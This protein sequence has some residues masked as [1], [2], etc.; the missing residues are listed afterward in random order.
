MSGVVETPSICHIS[1]QAHGRTT[2][3]QGCVV[4]SGY[5][6]CEWKRHVASGPKHFIAEYKTLEYSFPV[7]VT[8]KAMVPAAN[9][10]E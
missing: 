1:F 8:E 6:R 7:A 9:L 2:V 10:Q 4:S 5:G 3:R